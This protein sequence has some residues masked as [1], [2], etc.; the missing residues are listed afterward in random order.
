M[1]AA[2]ALLER[3]EAARREGAVTCDQY[4]YTAT[5]TSLTALLPHWAH[6]GGTPACCAGH[7]P[8]QELKDAIE[9]M[10]NRGGPEDPDF[11]H[12]WTPPGVGG[13]TVAELA[14][15]GTSAV[16]AVL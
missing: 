8:T 15:A 10:E 13:P 2:G 1:G 9:E 14:Q 6:D 12:A 11:R 4:P 5:S 16:D 7:A 3:I